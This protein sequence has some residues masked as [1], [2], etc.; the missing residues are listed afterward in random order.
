MLKCVV[1]CSIELI[2]IYIIYRLIRR[3][4]VTWAP[5]FFQPATL[6]KAHVSLIYNN[7]LSHTNDATPLPE[8]SQI[9]CHTHSNR[10]NYMRHDNQR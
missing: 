8:A 2:T 6:P 1:S 7:T 10:L 3:R 5:F 4:V 9:L